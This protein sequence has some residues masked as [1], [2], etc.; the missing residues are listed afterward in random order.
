MNELIINYPK[1][2]AMMKVTAGL[3]L[4]KA[5]AIVGVEFLSPTKYVI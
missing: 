1:G 2:I 5:H 4:D 3:I